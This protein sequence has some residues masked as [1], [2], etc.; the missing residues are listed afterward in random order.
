MIC[1]TFE[2][3]GRA[4]LRHTT[5]D[6]IL[7]KDEGVI[8]SRRADGMTEAGRWSF[9][10][11]Y[12]DRDETVTQALEREVREEVAVA[13][14]SAVLFAVVSDPKRDPIARQNVSLVFLVTEW[15]GVPRVGMEVSAIDVFDSDTIPVVQEMASDHHR[16]LKLYFDWKETRR[17]LPFVM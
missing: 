4:T 15:D 8:L 14:R 12:V 6:G 5:V 9:P 11:G 16:I 10:G 7:V 2:D 13:V 1:C 3:G 17:A